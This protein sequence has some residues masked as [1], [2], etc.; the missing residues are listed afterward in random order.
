[1]VPQEAVQV[2]PALAVNC[3]VAPSARVTLLGEMV[4][5][6]GAPEPIPESAT[7][8][9]LFVALSAI[10]R[11]AVRVPLPVG[12]KRRVSVQEVEPARLEPQVFL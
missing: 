8:C 9:G 4:S 6:V 5:D 11:V 10:E 2:T 12:L 7:S 1:M 3:C